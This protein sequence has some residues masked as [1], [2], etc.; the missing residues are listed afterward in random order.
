VSTPIPHKWRSVD[1][2]GVGAFEVR[3]PTLR[4]TQSAAPD[5]LAWWAVC[6]RRDGVQLTRDEVLD[7][8]AEV[9]G[10]LAKEVVAKRPTSPPSGGSSGSHQA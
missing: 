8:D 3:R 9:A 6:V 2:E 10:M 5:D 7:M 4:D 1:L